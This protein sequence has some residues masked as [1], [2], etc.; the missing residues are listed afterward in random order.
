VTVRNSWLERKKASLCILAGICAVSV[1]VILFSGGQNRRQGSDSYAV[2]I[3][4]YGV[5]AAEM[6]RS[7]AIPLEDALA[8][9]PGA[10][11]VRSSSE[12]SAARVFVSFNGNGNGRGRGR[13][14]YEAVRE[15]A[16]RVYESLPASAQ[17][18]EIQSSD[19]TRIPV[20]SAAVS[21]T[22]EHSG[23]DTARYLER[24]IK[25]RLES[26]EGAGEALVSGTGL[27]EIIIALD[28]EKTAALGLEPSAVA[29]ALGMNDA[30]FSGGVIG[31]DREI[32]VTVD[33]R[34]DP[35]GVD[36]VA[37]LG[38]ALIPLGEG[39]A[40]PLAEIASIY[41]QER[42]PD[43]LS[44]LNGKQTAV[45]SVM[46]SS[47]ADLR[48]LSREIRR[49]LAAR[50]LPLQF[51]VLSDRGAEEAAAFRSVFSAAMQGAGMAALIGFLLRRGAQNNAGLF[52]ALS[53]PAACLISGA[54]LVVLGFPPDRSA[55]AGIAAG[56]GAAVDSVILCSEKLKSCRSYGDARAALS[57][58][59]GP[60]LAG[61][62]TTVAALL[63]LPAMAPGELDVIAY[64]IAVVTITALLLA[65]CLL[66][67][68]LLW[69]MNAPER[70]RRYPI[71]QAPGIQR[72]FRR[73]RRIACR[74]L[75]ADVRLCTCRPRWIAAAVLAVSAAGILALYI[76]GV[77]S[78][79][80]GSGDSVYA[81][82]EF[83][84]GL[85]AETVDRILAE[86]GERL[87]RAG[88]INN[89]ETGARTGAGSVMIAFDPKQ[90]TSAEARELAR[91][92]AIPGGFLF[93][94][95]T[96]AAERYWEIN[97][98]GDDEARCRQLAEA[99]ARSAAAYPLVRERVL[100][101]KQGSKKLTLLPDRERLAQS[102]IAFSRAADTA[103]RGVHGPVAY[104]R[105]GRDGETDVRAR[106]GEP[107]AP[108][109]RS[110]T[111]GLLV[112]AA[113]LESLTRQREGYEPSSI[114]REDR[115][116]TASITV[117]TKP[118][119]PRRVRKELAGLLAGLELPPGYAV[120]F[121][122]GAIQ[123]AEALSKTVLFFA[124]ALAF[125]YMV[126]ASV[127]ESF[128]LPLAILSAVPPSLA[129]PA[130]CLAALGR[131]FNPA[132]A[133]AFVAVSG[134]TVNAAVLCA[135]GM[136]PLYKTAGGKQPSALPSA[137]PPAADDFPLYRA[138]RRNMPS[139]LATAATTIAGALPFLLLREGAN[140]L[141]RTLSLVTA[142]G[143]GS[144]CF[145]SISAVPALVI[146]AKDF[147][148]SGR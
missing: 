22:G 23:I 61:S 28:Q 68:L 46:G 100:N 42:T 142:L 119:D 19:D 98:F 11:G 92:T 114:R 50:P 18:P 67:P 38:E 107:G 123:R 128:V 37:A 118:M 8:S 135:G 17:R 36:A 2:T 144:S 109:S 120:E 58:L 41:E 5:D 40:A 33:G 129:I 136:E 4:H 65:L 94:P 44:R 35:A 74:F 76:R 121:D 20:W 103:R 105:I 57:R 104:K 138:L 115:R 117:S 27:R 82:V 77:D 55:L 21:E 85:P 122:P 102:G 97:I 12:N 81:R 90:I 95:E 72:G 43:T 9:I 73:V 47:G 147:R 83:E 101:F 15:A 131:P 14:R 64:A 49:E 52:C 31:R 112:S 54:L 1:C 59:R 3:R 24:I 34:Y 10:R 26:L 70:A 145:W 48:K 99:L 86:Y 60:L 116:R 45:I 139:L 93:F 69:D 96:S 113:R 106:T 63:P 53:V 146:M 25:P 110:E 108:P 133:C 16:Q 66:P 125:C 126:I 132:A 7:A 6:E 39:R 134:M 91:G 71:R 140:T 127:H 51:T 79:A 111:L 88:G 141:V 32:L 143:V 62:A 13:G 148:L 80:Y 137:S 29:A 56:V 124:L 87:A 75:A 84:G 30:L 89:V 78:D 130:I